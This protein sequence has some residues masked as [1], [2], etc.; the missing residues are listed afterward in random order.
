[1]AYLLQGVAF[2]NLSGGQLFGETVG[3]AV[4]KA[5]EQKTLAAFQLELRSAGFDFCFVDAAKEIGAVG[6]RD[7]VVIRRPSVNSPKL[8]SLV[9]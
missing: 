1:M 7:Y 8:R 6:A 4:F 5:G 9:I 2:I 3:D